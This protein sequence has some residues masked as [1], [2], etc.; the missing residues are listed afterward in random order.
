MRKGDRKKAF[1]ET[2]KREDTSTQ[3]SLTFIDTVGK[4][5]PLKLST[6]PLGSVVE[7]IT[8]NDKVIS[9]ILIVGTRIIYFASSKQMG[10]E[11][12][13]ERYCHSL[14][15]FVAIRYG[16]YAII[17]LWLSIV[18]KL[19]YCRTQRRVPTLS[20]FPKSSK[21]HI[22]QRKDDSNAS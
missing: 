4:G 16:T 7:R 1:H 12:L 13:A 10:T 2:F 5:Q 21:A 22:R 20:T 8:S 19:Q 11:A 17:C 6:S 18:S 3:T 15:L 14:F 9:S